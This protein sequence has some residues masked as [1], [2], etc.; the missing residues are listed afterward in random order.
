MIYFVSI[1]YENH[2]NTYHYIQTGNKAAWY[3][4]DFQVTQMQSNKQNCNTNMKKHQNQ[5]E[6]NLEEK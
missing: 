4:S 2:T 6:Q 3:I 5:I 1:T